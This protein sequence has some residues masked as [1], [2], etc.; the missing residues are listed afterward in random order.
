MHSRTRITVYAKCLFIQW[1]VCWP[2]FAGLSGSQLLQSM[3]ENMRKQNYQGSYV[4]I[5]DN[6]V[7]TMRVLHAYD[8]EMGERERITSL[9]GEAREIFRDAQQITCIWPV[10]GNV[11]IG[12]SKPKSL[13][14]EFDAATLSRLQANY[15]FQ[16]LG[17]RRI[18]GLSGVGVAIRPVDSYRYGYE[19]TV[20]QVGAMLLHYATLDGMGKAIEQVVFTELKPLESIDAALFSADSLLK[21]R[22]ASHWQRESQEEEGESLLQVQNALP[23]RFEWLPP[24]FSLER[25]KVQ[26]N[27]PSI[28]GSYHAMVTDGM[29][30]ISVFGEPMLD[31]KVPGQSLLL[32]G[33]TMGAINAFGVTQGQWHLTV[34][35]EVP[36]ATVQQVAQSIVIPE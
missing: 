9:N 6:V 16:V 17:E 8:E 18:A 11:T 10:S 20:S 3:S 24:G 2:A 31:A 36:A 22:E 35:G 1:L 4:Y 32:G 13:F 28:S 15:R 12:R 21:Q 5:H 23:W 26:S 25:T 14:P 30:S 19:V 7:E 27:V 34:V 29:A 33:S